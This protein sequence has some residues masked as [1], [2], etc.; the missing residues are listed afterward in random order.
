[1]TDS[2]QESSG[3]HAY[4]VVLAAD[5]NFGL[6]LA[7][8]ALSIA[9]TL[10]PGTGLDL[11]VFDMG[12]KAEKAALIR[13]T[14]SRPNVNLRWETSVA[15]K[16]AELP[17]TWVNIT[18]AGYARL[19][20]PE[21]LPASATRAL[22]V[23]CDVMARR[24]V[25]ELIDTDFAGNVAM[26]VPDTQSPFVSSPHAVPWWFASG[27]DVGEPNFN[28]GVLLMN[29]EAWRTENLAGHA[30]A[31]LTDG[32]H[33][34]GQDQEAINAVM[35]SRIGHVDPRWNQQSELADRVYESLLP[36]TT[37]QLE[38]L[39]DDPWIVHFSNSRKP[40]SRSCDNPRTS[41]W[42]SYLDRTAFAGW[43]PSFAKDFVKRGKRVPRWAIAQLR[44][45]PP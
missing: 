14:L 3:E 7:V 34:F 39:R 19:F 8:A 10:A 43:R 21:V 23:D 5:D 13:K 44:M 42:Y 17:N 16:V 33:E 4:S 2:A 32:R 22:Y 35:G 18:R 28:S 25:T 9:L 24:S 1:M 45:S 20:I 27:R 31:Y 37:K 15:K 36:F 40:W 29:L 41:E 38:Q 26:G 11:Y 30:L 6:P 12:I